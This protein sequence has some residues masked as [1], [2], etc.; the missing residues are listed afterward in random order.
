M[1][2]ITILE[3]NEHHFL[4]KLLV[5]VGAGFLV[6]LEREHVRQRES[7]EG[8]FAGV[9]TFTLIALC[10]FLAAF[11]SDRIHPY[12]FLVGFGGFIA[13]VIAAYA[14]MARKGSVGGTSEISNILVFLIGAIIYA[15]QVLLGVAVAVFM[16]LLLSF[17]MS[18]HQF[19]GRLR[20]NELRA[21]VQF[22]VIS[23]LV[24]PFLPEGS[25]GPYDVWNLREIWIMVILV[26]GVSLVGYLLTKVMGGKGTI[27]TGMVGG[28][29][30]STVV[31]MSFAQRSRTMDASAARPFA[32]S[33]LMASTIMFPRLL[34]ILFVL[35]PPLA[36]RLLV[37]MAIFTAVGT[38]CSFI[39]HRRNGQI[40]ERPPLRNPLNF[41]AA[42]KF[43]AIFAGVKLLMRYASEEYGEAG[44]YVASVLSGLTNMD[45]ITLSMARMSNSNDTLALAAKAII[46]AGI[47]NTIMKYLIVLFTGN[48]A[49][50]KDITIGFAAITLA[51][52]LWLVLA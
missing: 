25:F 48:V 21:I 44:I 12:T 43:A 30:S 20:L 19:I 51:G 8:Q 37:P 5:A 1:D 36:L 2:E 7:E 29:V 9:R 47:A 38:I 28:L 10:G 45:A 41:Q 50:K 27:V 15:D 4:L 3:E 16:V 11:V 6:G 35:D 31:T 52:V 18:L 23:A 32:I 17:K 22:V 49:L 14:Q 34:L 46:M 33:I 26:S 13:L 40:S 24:L 42:L 39:L